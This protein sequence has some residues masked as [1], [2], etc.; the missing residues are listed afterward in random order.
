MSTTEKH[1]P[2]RE[3]IAVVR[4]IRQRALN[5]PSRSV[6]FVPHAQGLISTPFVAIRTNGEP[7]AA[8]DQ[9]GRPCSRRIRS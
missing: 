2:W 1:T 9:T 6:Y 5:V 3:V 4:D 7:D 8:V